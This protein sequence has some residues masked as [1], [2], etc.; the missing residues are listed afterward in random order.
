MFRF[1]IYKIRK[2]AKVD[3]LGSDEPHE[4]EYDY[5]VKQIFF[6]HH[7][8]ITLIGFTVGGILVGR[9][10]YEILVTEFGLLATIA[11]GLLLFVATGFYLG[12]FEG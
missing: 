12:S 6:G 3:E 10:L 8:L 5:D 9:A 11:A 1:K 4:G 7:T 2:G